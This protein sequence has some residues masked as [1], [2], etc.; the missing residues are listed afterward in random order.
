MVP[1]LMYRQVSVVEK[2][3]ER[4]HGVSIRDMAQ[5]GI[6]GRLNVNHRQ[7]ILLKLEHDIKVHVC[8]YTSINEGA[9]YPWTSFHLH[10]LRLTSLS[11]GTQWW[12]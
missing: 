8:Y 5:M 2:W 4:P 12:K 6:H 9:Y 10:L 3:R 7:A 11:A 1:R